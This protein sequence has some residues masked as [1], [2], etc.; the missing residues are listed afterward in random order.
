MLVPGGPFVATWRDDGEVLDRLE[1]VVQVRQII[2]FFAPNDPASQTRLIRI[3]IERTG[4]YLGGARAWWRCPC[5]GRRVALLYLAN[6]I[7]CVRCLGLVYASQSED[8]MARTWR[9][10]LEIERRLSCSDERWNGWEQ[11]KGMRKATFDRLRA[12]L[13]DIA[14]RRGRI[15]RVIALRA[16]PNLLNGSLRR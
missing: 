5:C 11:S 9:K 10:Q 6:V 16:F 7:A 4:C 15:F 14:A 8:A 1:V 3:E 12:T 2:A 13:A